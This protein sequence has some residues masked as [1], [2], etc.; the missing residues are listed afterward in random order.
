MV[1]TANG[2]WIIDLGKMTCENIINKIVLKFEKEGETINGIITEMPFELVKKLARE[3]A[4]K[5]NE[6]KPIKE[7]VLEA[8]EL[9][10]HTYFE[11]MI[12]SGKKILFKA[13]KEKRRGP[14]NRWR[15]MQ[16]RRPRQP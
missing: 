12:E 15:P 11:N 10:L 2:E 9:F 6:Q 13:N 1:Y 8:E 16:R 5:T 7:A 3:M 4:A 14:G